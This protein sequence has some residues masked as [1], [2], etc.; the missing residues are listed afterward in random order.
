MSWQLIFQ[1]ISVCAWAFAVIT[2]VRPLC[3]GRKATV[4]LS[5]VLAAAFG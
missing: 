5:A 4:I 1:V 3:L 2:V